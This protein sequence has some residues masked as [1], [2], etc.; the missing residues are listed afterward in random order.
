MTY[1][2]WYRNVYIIITHTNGSPVSI[3][4]IRLCYSVHL[5]AGKTK[6]AEN[7]ITKLGTGTVHHNTLPTNEY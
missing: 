4:L 7:K 5:I 3:V 1:G 6:M 2:Q